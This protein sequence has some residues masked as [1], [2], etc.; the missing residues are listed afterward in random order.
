MRQEIILSLLCA[1][2]LLHPLRLE[3]KVDVQ[4]SGRLVK[5]KWSQSSTKQGAG[6]IGK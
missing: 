3:A 2:V 6:A 5:P 4:G 1:N